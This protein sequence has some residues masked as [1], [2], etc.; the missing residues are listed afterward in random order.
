MDEKLNSKND[1]ADLDAKL[2]SMLEEMD[3]DEDFA[4]TIG[5]VSTF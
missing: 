4:I 1:Y 5:K 2:Q 3:I